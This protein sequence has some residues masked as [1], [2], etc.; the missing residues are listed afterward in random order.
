MKSHYCQW[1]FETEAAVVET[2]A[3][4]Y[5]KPLAS[6]S[7]QMLWNSAE[8]TDD[9][10]MF[11]AA[12][13]AESVPVAAMETREVVDYPPGPGFVADDGSARCQA[14]GCVLCSTY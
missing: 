12:A 14:P 5:Y 1:Y 6:Y 2:L 4:T 3:D 8:Q 9:S 13:A 10:A 7:G 11:A